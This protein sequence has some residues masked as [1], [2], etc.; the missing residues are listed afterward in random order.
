MPIYRVLHSRVVEFTIDVEAPDR[1]KA[2]GL[3]SYGA[4]MDGQETSSYWRDS[5]VTG[6]W[7]SPEEYEKATG[8]QAGDVVKL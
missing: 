1:E 3:E 7:D 2:T 5:V 8:E 4:A 6:I